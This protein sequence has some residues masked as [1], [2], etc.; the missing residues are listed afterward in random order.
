MAAQRAFFIGV[1]SR[2]VGMVYYLL[3]TLEIEIPAN[4]SY[5]YDE[6]NDVYQDEITNFNSTVR[7]I[8]IDYQVNETIQRFVREYP[9]YL[10]MNN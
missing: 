4:P 9:V 7:R 1:E 3:S 2:F 10:L 5:W 6:V 8:V